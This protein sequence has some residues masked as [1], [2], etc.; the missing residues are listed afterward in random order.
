MSYLNILIYILFWLVII[1]T[2]WYW[3][4]FLFGFSCLPL[5]QNE[6]FG[7][8]SACLIF[9]HDV[10]SIYH[11]NIGKIGNNLCLYFDFPLYF[12]PPSPGGLLYPPM[13]KNLFGIQSTWSPVFKLVELLWGMMGLL[14]ILI[15]MVKLINQP[16]IRMPICG[17][18]IS[19]RI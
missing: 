19:L 18:H 11:L 14:K 3:E 13:V 15:Y 9:F 12:T 2:N 10:G 1:C 8:T 6:N 7:S 5:V 17:I 16:G 4:L